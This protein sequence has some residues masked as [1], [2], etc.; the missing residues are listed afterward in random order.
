M[1][2]RG[3]HLFQSSGD[4]LADRRYGFALD[5][6]A[7]GDHA[8]AVDLLMQAVDIAPRFASAWFSLGELHERLGCVAE[9]I[10]AFQRAC[11]AD[12]EDCH[13]ASLRLAKLGAQNR[14]AMPPGYV[15]ALFDQ[16]APRFDAALENLGYQ[17]PALLLDAIARCCRQRGRHLRFDHVLDLGCGTGLAGAALRPLCDRLVGVDLS[18]AMVAKAGQKRLYDRLEVAEIG[19]FM[20]A[21]AASGS[22]YD[23]I[24]AA[25]VLPYVG[26]LAPLLRQ[27][28][29]LLAANSLLGFTVETHGSDGVVLGGKLRFAHSEAC[30]H[31]ALGA[32]GLRLCVLERVPTRKDGG[33]PV[34]SLVV[35]AGVS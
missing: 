1:E 28:T 19:A 35:V 11:D 32:G 2:V 21:E 33:L 27:A 10:V 22:R 20:A 23:L 13:G 34:A 3:D 4:L 29:S 7:R 5:L 8:G 30:V 25:D 9:A 31:E 14:G 16:Y 18:P 12:T 24:L 26:D 15:R 17:A 6:A